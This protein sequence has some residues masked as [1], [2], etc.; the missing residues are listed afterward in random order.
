VRQYSV[1]IRSL[2][3]W[4]VSSVAIPWSS[5]FGVVWII[6]SLSAFGEKNRSNVGRDRRT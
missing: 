1:P 2:D 6:Q 4:C 5:V 3:R